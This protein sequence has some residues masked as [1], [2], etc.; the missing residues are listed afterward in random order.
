MPKDKTDNF[1]KAIKRY[2]KEQKSAM[3]GEVKLLKTERLKEAEETAK[4]ESQLLIKEKQREARSRRT[5]ELA[6]KTQ[7][8]RRRLFIARSEM[9]DEVF[10]LAADRLIEYVK[11]DAYAAMLREGAK[12]VAELFG[13]DSCVLY[14]CERDLGAA[15]ELKSFFSGSVEVKADQAIRIGGVKGFCESRGMIADETLD[16]RLEAQREWFIEHA[17]LSVQ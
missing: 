16:S 1:L 8:G 7:E 6:S 14:V 13:N 5:A 12:A 9:V 17:A 4:R 10:A 15:E 2:A 11:T 3:H